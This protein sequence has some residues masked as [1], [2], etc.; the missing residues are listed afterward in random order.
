MQVHTHSSLFLSPSLCLSLSDFSIFVCL[1]LFH[2]HMLHYIVHALLIVLA[3]LC[4]GK[5]LV[6][7][8]CHSILHSFIPCVCHMHYWPTSLCDNSIHMRLQWHVHD[9]L[10]A[11]LMYS[12]LRLHSNRKTKNIVFIKAAYRQYLFL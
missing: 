5:D 9:S 12:L 2:I 10:I 3:V 4:V 7:L 8:G 1:S 6:Y 11:N